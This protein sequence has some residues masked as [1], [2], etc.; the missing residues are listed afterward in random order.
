MK[1]LYLSAAF[2]LCAT[3][4]TP[5][6]SQVDSL[7]L[8]NGDIIVGEVKGMD[9]GVVTIE[10]DYSD[11]DFK[12]EW[13]GISSIRTESIFLI[14]MTNGERYNGRISSNGE[15]KINIVGEDNVVVDVDDIVYLDDFG[16]SFLD[17][18]YATIG[19]GLNLTKANNF[20][21]LS[22]N[23]T[24]GYLTERYS[25]DLKFNDLTSNQD[26]VAATERT[27]G[28]LEFRY[29]L[30][31]SWYLAAAV[32]FLSNTE[33]AIQLR[34]TGRL[35]AGYFVVRTNK[36]YWN[37]GAGAS[38]NLENFSNETPDRQSFEG[39]IGTEINLFNITD[40]SL[41]SNVFAYPSFTE[42]GRWRVDYMI[43]TK[44]DLPLDFYIGLNFTLNYDNQPAE[45]GKEVDYVFG[46]TFGWDW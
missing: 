25:L 9:K 28:A 43:N 27:D 34:S 16:T 2:L 33:Q 41:V 21:Q 13:E 17:N 6:F 23:A 11:S 19:V 35:G 39:Y 20:R 22:V 7:I 5:L 8:I 32:N 24:A 4:F 31:K 18:F 40:F 14:N 38:A 3:F 44:Y 26:S 36:L 46:A 42:S 15:D 30:P 12:I 29:L 37:F 45:V 1:K 10:T